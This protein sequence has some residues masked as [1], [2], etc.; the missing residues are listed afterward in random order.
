MHPWEVIAAVG[1][2]LAVMAVLA[3]MYRRRRRSERLQPRFGAE[4]GTVVEFGNHRPSRF[5]LQPLSLSDRVRFQQEWKMCESYFVIDPVAAVYAA[6]GL[7]AE[8]MHSCG[9]PT[10]AGE[11]FKDFSAQ[12]PWLAQNYLQARETVARHRRGNASTEEM[13][14]AMVRY[15]EVFGELLGEARD[16]RLTRVS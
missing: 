15:R 14:Q 11:R 10:E 9:C 6:D 16:V 12:R 13:R 7:I 2:P 1:S 5:R 4:Y 3:W 8:V